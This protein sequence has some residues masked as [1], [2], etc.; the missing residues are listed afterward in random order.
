MKPAPLIAMDRRTVDQDGRLRVPGCRISKANVCPYY[1][2]EIP[3]ADRL[4]LDPNRVY[5]LYRD[6]EE[7]RKAAKSFEQIP[8][9][10]THIAVTASAPANDVV[11]GTVSNIRFEYPYLVGDL[12]VWR[13]DAINKILSEQTKELSSAY[14]YDA[15][16]QSGT[17]PEGLRYDI[18]MA[19]LLGNHLALVSTGRAGPDVVVADSLPEGFSIMKFPKFLAAMIAAVARPDDATL[20]VAAD[21]ALTAELDAMDEL[22][23]AEKKTAC[24]AM[25]VEKGCAAD[26]LTDDDK[27]EA[28]KRAAADKRAK[29]G[30]S[31]GTPKPPGMDAAA[32]QVAVDA[33]VATA[34]AAATVAAREGYV[35]AADAATVSAEQIAAARAAGAAESRALFEARALVAPKVGDVAN[36][37]TAEGVFRFA[38]DHLKV[39]HKDIPATALAT[40]YKGVT[41]A[42]AP[43]AADAATVA[44]TNV[45]DLF[46]AAKF[47]SR[48]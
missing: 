14:R 16:L 44:P 6:P 23:D 15:I 37:D 28:Y 30:V 25:A 18:K 26:A 36:V 1:G 45:I 34:V 32:V 13:Q 17:S 10:M 7:L 12:I 2:R 27:T 4:G 43:L 11:C 22:T 21:A 20:V 39:E 40:F 38:L 48:S 33:A 5:M 3:N 41:S 35:L 47:I 24:D 42:A 46:P 8:L 31:V 29:D 19:S 9:L